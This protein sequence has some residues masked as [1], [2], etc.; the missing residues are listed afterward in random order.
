MIFQVY[1]R[2]LNHIQT[3]IIRHIFIKDKDMTKQLKKCIHS[4]ADFSKITKQ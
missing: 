4:G 1:W 2:T 3:T